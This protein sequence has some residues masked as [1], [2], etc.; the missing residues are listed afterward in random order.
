MHNAV[1]VLLV[2]EVDGYYFSELEVDLDVLYD[3]LLIL[4]LVSEELDLVGGDDVLVVWIFDGFGLDV[5][6]K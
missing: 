5:G 2:L 3:L 1:L 4:A 6:G